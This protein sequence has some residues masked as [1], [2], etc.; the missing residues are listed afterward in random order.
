MIQ[1]ETSDRN[2]LIK[3]LVD[4]PEMGN[5]RSRQSVLENAGL[6]QFVVRID[7][8]GEAFISVS[9]IVTHLSNYGSFEDG[10][11]ALGRLLVTVKEYTGRENK[12]L[13]DRIIKK[14]NL[15]P[16]TNP[17]QIETNN[18][19]DI[20]ASYNNRI[21]TSPQNLSNETAKYDQRSAKIYG[22]APEAKG[23]NI[24]AGK[25]VHVET[26]IGTQ[27]IQATPLPKPSSIPSNIINRGTPYFVGRD[28]LLQELHKILELENQLAI[29]ALAG[30]GGIGKTELVIQYALR[31]QN[32]YPGGLCWLQVRGGADLG[33][34]IVDFGRYF[35][36]LNPAKD[37][38]LIGGAKYCWRNWIE[39]K[40]L[41]ILDDI[42]NFCDYYKEKIL[43]FLPPAQPRFKV[44]MTSRQNPGA[45][46]RGIDLDV[47]SPEAS[48]ELLRSLIGSERLDAERALAKALC[49]WLG[50]LPLGL[51]LM[52]RYL[53]LHPTLT[54]AK[55]I[56][57]LEKKKLAARAL[58]FQKEAD[59]TAK[60][61]VAA[62]FDLSWEELAQEAQQLGC[63][64]SLFVSA[65][66]DWSLVENCAIQTEDEE[67]WEEAQEELE[68]LRDSFLVNRH[69]LQLTKQQTYRLHPLIREFF[70]AK[71]EQLANASEYKRN[72]CQAIVEVAKTIPN[73][74][75]REQIVELTPA[76]PH[77]AEVAET[78]TDWVRDEDLISPFIGLG[79]FYQ[80]QGAYDQAL[81]WLTNC[82]STVKNHLGDEHPNIA[83][84]LNN[85]AYLYSLQ[86]RYEQAEP[87][88]LQA[89]EIAKK[90]FGD[91]HSNIANILNNLAYLYSLQGRYEQAEPL[92]L[93]V[94][95]MRRK[96]LG[97]EHSD[98]AVSLSSLAELYQEQGRYEEAEP[99]YLESIEMT[100]KHFGDETHLVGSSLNGLAIVYG[101]QGRYEE[102]EP[103]YLQSLEIAK[104]GFGYE[105]PYVAT[106]L[107]SLAQFYQSQGRY[108]EAELLYLEVLERRKKLLLDEHPFFAYSLNDLA[109]LYSLQG[110]YEEAEPLYLESIEMRKKLLLDEHPFFAV[111]LSS[112]AELYREQGRY[113]EAEPLFLKALEVRKKLLGEEH[114]DVA[115]SLWN[116]GRLY[117]DRE[118]YTKAQPLYEQAL[119]IAE[120]KLGSN[121]PDTIK[122]REGLE[123]VLT[124]KIR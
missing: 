98:V 29:C 64:L 21:N 69:L 81:P 78:L 93:Q 51:E 40:V 59:M 123:F 65:P 91:E 24:I 116:L 46:I 73:T 52:G 99:L 11:T 41:V 118:Q 88:Y 43:P 58:S 12:D 82:L 16:I 122:I 14:Y 57:R 25:N 56:E 45:S 63:R 109:N 95:E 114:P 20:T 37:L 124:Q 113:E 38:G 105:H 48:L 112:L 5:H 8:S 75:T 80:G 76:I 110:R 83:D 1:L 117:Q 27:I 17:I 39:G 92:Y 120:T 104:K 15:N 49:E 72:F 115:N 62:A 70:R 108:E 26:A 55:A 119:H 86:G 3:L 102:A 36:N 9:E 60:L 35:L 71:L 6:Q 7:L 67:Q 111:S 94:V 44:L 101:E 53:K 89:F 121:H 74:P 13:I 18:Q 90:H 50:Y 19:E 79:Y 4:I 66:F 30:M 33:S 22:N 54:I 97:N 100:K 42:P 103:L 34:Q 23:S 68:E 32:N 96:L 31:Y 84:I 106:S 28:D 10:D 61:G 47:L 87:L 107:N 2:S 85:L 77:I